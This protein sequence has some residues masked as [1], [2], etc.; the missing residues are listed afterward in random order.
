MEKRRRKRKRDKDFRAGTAYKVLI[1]V[2]TVLFVLSL[3]LYVNEKVLHLEFLPTTAEISAALDGKT[4]IVSVA[5]GEISVHYIDVGQG[6]CQ[7]IVAGNTRVLIDSGEE[8]YADRV[9]HYISKMGF[10]RLDYVIATHQHTDH[11]GGM[12]KILEAFSIGKFIMPQVPDDLIP[13]GKEFEQMLDVIEKRGIT[14]EYSR[15]GSSIQLGNGAKL[16]FLGPVHDDYISLNNYSI[17][18]RLVHGER[19]FLFTGDVERAAES[20]LVNSGENLR[21]DVLKIPHHGSTSSSTPSFIEAINPRYAVISVG[22]GNSYGHPKTE[23][24]SRLSKHN[25]EI[26]TTMQSGTVVFVSDGENFTIYSD[27]GTGHFR[28]EEAV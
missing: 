6:D 19:S 11:I 7:L 20:D 5:E 9:I 25:C 26:I 1:G 2:F 21:S 15:Q 3:G 16:D 27:G 18:C 12:S 17:V 14:A 8:I 23:V 28:E 24:L 13:M 22:K 10:R 4:N